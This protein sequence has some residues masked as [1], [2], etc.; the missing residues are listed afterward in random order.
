VL[1]AIE[2]GICSM[3]FTSHAPVP[4][5]SSWN[6]DPQA[7]P[8][9]LG[10]IEALRQKYSG[11]LDIYKS[12]EIDFIPGVVGP[13][14]EIIRSAQ[15]DFTLGSVHYLPLPGIPGYIEIDGPHNKFHALLRAAFYGDIQKVVETVFEHTRTMIRDAC[16]DVI[17]HLDK[18][19]IQN[20]ATN[21]WDPSAG[22][23]KKAV[24]HTLEEIR[25]S[26]AIVEV[27]TRGMYKKGTAEPYPAVWILEHIRD[28]NIPICLNSDAHH[29][30]EITRGF[31]AAAELLLTMGFRTLKVLSHGAWKDVPFDQTGLD[32]S[33]IKD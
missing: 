28:M 30:G 14:S 17:G 18:I 16:P 32:I 22:W 6:M 12:L 2:Q 29:P 8:G 1:A 11:I 5:Q 20:L 31:S 7:L 33:L 21:L 23:Y 27:N 26:R 15:L 25:D 4:F 9:Y 10:E 13:D 3:A 19:I 24:V